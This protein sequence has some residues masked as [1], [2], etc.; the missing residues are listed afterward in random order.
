MN[1][2]VLSVI[3]PVYNTA[4]WLRRCLDSICAQSYRNLEILCVNDGS[5]DNSAEILAEY[6]ARDARIRVFTQENAGLS[7]ARNTALEHV[8]GEWVAGVDSDDYLA[9]DLF[10][11]AVSCIADEVDMVAYGMLEK[12]EDAPEGDTVFEAYAADEVQPM[13]VE[14]AGHM[15]VC[16][17]N[18]LWR[19]SLIKV[20][21]LR[22]PHGLVH[23]DD[24]F[25][26]QFIPYV[27]KVAF[28]S[29]VGYYYM[30]RR[31]SIM[32]SGQSLLLTAERYAKVVRY[33]HAEYEKRGMVPVQS[34]WFRLMVSRIYRDRSHH[35]P[36]KE[37]EALAEVFYSL[38]QELR[39]LPA[40]VG[41]YRFRCMIPVRGWRR[42][43]L[44]RYLN[45]EI[46]RFFGIPVWYVEYREG[47]VAVSSCKFLAWI[48]RKLTG[49]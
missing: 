12:W 29:A 44:S 17:C 9:P 36:E 14:Q 26:Y 41:D 18:K 25:F 19:Y 3:V 35:T 16:F 13:T 37:R 32:N 15:L 49:R 11:R 40:L 45:A 46:Y 31:G 48:K 10:E 4:P 30:Q 34:P 21:G 39:L 20:H 38:L 43:F 6:A 7:A 1:E 2:L 8:T 24:G 42:L 47:R 5:T 33:V 27:R 28:C 22:F 23:E